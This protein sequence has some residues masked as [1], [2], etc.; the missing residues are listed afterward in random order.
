MAYLRGAVAVALL[1]AVFVL[2]HS[3][4]NVTVIE[5]PNFTGNMTF[6]KPPQAP[7]APGKPGTPIS[8]L[9]AVPPGSKKLTICLVTGDR[10]TVYVKNGQVVKIVKPPGYKV[11]THD[12]RRYLI[13]KQGLPDWADWSLFDVEELANLRL[14]GIRY[15]SVQVN[16]SSMEALRQLASLL[17]KK[18]IKYT[19]LP[20]GDP[21]LV[22][23]LPGCRKAHRFT[24][25]VERHSG[26]V[27]KVLLSPPPPEEVL[28]RLIQE[29]GRG[30]VLPV[31][32]RVGMVVQ[33]PMPPV[34]GP[35]VGPAAVPGRGAPAVGNV[36]VATAPGAGSSAP[37]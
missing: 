15:L 29:A 17:A 3:G 27:E 21:V 11:V 28:Q 5:R 13:P 14:R 31:G 18:S 30:I 20:L 10:A 25:L 23:T 22:A 8:K 2:M 37:K 32:K 34:G 33:P 9:P 35:F 19:L 26:L 36:T 16:A 4:H 6:P 12:G 7:A 24:N 1:A